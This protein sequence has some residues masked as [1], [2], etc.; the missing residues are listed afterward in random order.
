MRNTEVGTVVVRAATGVRIRPV[1]AKRETLR[2]PARGN[3]D[4]V[5]LS[6]RPRIGLKPTDKHERGSVQQALKLAGSSWIPC[7]HEC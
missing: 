6:R 4:G 3:L 2:L 5:G 1:T 7:Q